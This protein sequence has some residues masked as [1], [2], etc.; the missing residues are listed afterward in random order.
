MHCACGLAATRTIAVNCHVGKRGVKSCSFYQCQSQQHGQKEEDDSFKGVS[1]Y[2]PQ[3]RAGTE[4]AQN[5]TKAPLTGNPNQL[6][7]HMLRDRAPPAPHLPHQLAPVLEQ[8]R[9][10]HS[11]HAVNTPIDY[12]CLKIG[13][14]ATHSTGN[15]AQAAPIHAAPLPHTRSTHAQLTA[16]VR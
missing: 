6:G 16:S 9:A 15:T 13:N 12:K 1:L 3:D 14:G 10:Q 8:D 7:P 2:C 4:V 5:S 11:K